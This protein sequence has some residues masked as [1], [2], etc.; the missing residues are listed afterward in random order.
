MKRIRYICSQRYTQWYI[1]YTYTFCFCQ[2]F[3][4]LWDRPACTCAKRE[5]NYVI[6][7]HSRYSAI[8]KRKL[9]FGTNFSL[10]PSIFLE[11]FFLRLIPWNLIWEYCSNQKEN[12]VYDSCMERKGWTRWL[13]NL[14]V[15]FT[16]CVVN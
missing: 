5:R 11:L 12:K 15:I 8:L 13:Y 9:V 7:C 3:S 6:H 2:I 16:C 14:D 10:S 4:L 1:M